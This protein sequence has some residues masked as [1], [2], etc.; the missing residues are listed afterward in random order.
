[1]HDPRLP[2]VYAHGDDDQ[3]PLKS[4]AI[5]GLMP[6]VG[7]G[8]LSGQWGAFKTFVALELASALITGSPFVGHRVKRQCGVMFIAAEGAGEVRLRLNA[9]VE[10]KC[11]GAKRAPFLWHDKDP[12]AVAT[13]RGRE[14]AP[15]WR[16]SCIASSCTN[17]GCRLG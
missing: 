4:W 10:H 6:V 1:M 7:H 12:G 11:S 15:R 5:K 2:P 3:Q 13:G 16:R 8:L 17:S 9:V 14:A